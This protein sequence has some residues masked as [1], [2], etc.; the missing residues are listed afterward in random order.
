MPIY[1]DESGGV[2]AGVMAFAAVRIDA[3][4]ADGLVRRFRTVTGLRGEMKGSRISL[5]ERALFFELLDRGGGKAIVAHAERAVFG[6]QSDIAIYAALLERVIAAWLPLVGGCAEVVIDDGRYG[7]D[8]LGKVRSDIAAMIGTCGRARLAH[9]DRSAGVQIADVV[10]NST[11]NRGA[12]TAR[13]TR[14][15][16]IMA[17]FVD[18]QMITLIPLTA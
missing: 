13:A 7:P 1:C 2:S 8:V 12:G 10:A 14:I 9:S 3:D 17:P 18:S 4:A 15:E 16:Q 11:Y 5:V 6:Q